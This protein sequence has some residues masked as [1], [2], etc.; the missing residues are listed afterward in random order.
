MAMRSCLPLF[1]G[2]F[3]L[4]GNCPGEPAPD[5]RALAWE[6][7]GTSLALTNHRKVVW[8]LVHDPE[9]PKSYFH[10][11]ATMDGK[12]L[13]AFEPADHRWHRGL[14][15]S[16][17]YINGLNYWE[18]DPKTGKSEGLTTVTTVK[19]EPADDF[20][21]KVEMGIVYQ[22][23]GQAV[24]LSENRDIHI[25]PPDADGTYTIDWHSCFTAADTPVKLDRTPPPHRGGPRHGGYAGL[26][27]RLARGLDD[28]Q[29]L[30]PDG[31][32]TPA[33]GHG[34][35]WRWIGAGDATSGIAIL[36][37][38]SN[39]RHA[40]PWYLHSDKVMLFFSPSPVFNDP[41]E[42][43]PRQSIALRYRVVV[44]SSPLSADQLNARWQKFT[45]PEPNPST[46]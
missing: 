13:T 32:T 3:L 19:A 27:L 15:W 39:P 12:V 26:S 14:W 8:R 24:L 36:E 5:S 46:P 40:P 6:K 29:F 18:E 1:A 38:S 33:L 21:A 16:W 22:P 37:Y 45:Q 43:A 42:I 20:S 4:A 35:P 23:P 41:I 2:V 31:P 10:P 28:Y 9:R 30:S 17:K 44:Q 11:L 25:G 7:T 34:K